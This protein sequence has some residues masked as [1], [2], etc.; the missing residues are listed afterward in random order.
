MRATEFTSEK[1]NPD[2]LKSGFKQERDI[3]NGQ[4][5][6][7]AAGSDNR[8]G[9]SLTITVFTIA[10]KPEEVGYAGFSVRERREDNEPHLRAGM[11]AISPRFRKLGIA[12]EIYKFA[13]DIG[14][15]IMPST[16]QTDD[17][18]AMWGGLQKHIR[19]P[20]PVKTTEPEAKPGFFDRIKKFAKVTA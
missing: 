15:D 9:G 7:V 14:N 3:L 1:I 19:Q 17:G 6:M 4:Y 5:R 8:Y 20:E 11:I 2:S 12:K 10:D 16:N 13:N 18:K